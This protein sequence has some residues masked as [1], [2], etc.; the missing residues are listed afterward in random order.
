MYSP[1]A[2]GET[3]PSIQELV[4]EVQDWK[5]E[6]RQEFGHEKVQLAD[7]AKLLDAETL[8]RRPEFATE[9]AK[10]VN[11]TDFDLLS[12]RIQKRI[13]YAVKIGKMTG[14]G[15]EESQSTAEKFVTIEG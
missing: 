6:S 13:L 11:D 2:G 12:I 5:L 10:L 9:F 1:L 14:L 4:P 3:Q 15:L 7:A 8:I